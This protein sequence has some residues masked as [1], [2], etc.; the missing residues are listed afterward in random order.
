MKR[1]MIRKHFWSLIIFITLISSLGGLILL[2]KS[3]PEKVL[4]GNEFEDQ[5]RQHVE[6]VP[7]SYYVTNP[8]TSGNHNAEPLP[9]QIYNT[10]ISDERQVHNLEH[11]GVIIQYKDVNDI[12][13]AAKL[14]DLYNNT[15]GSFGKIILAPRSNMDSKI[16]LTSWTRL[17][18]L[19]EFDSN[20]ISTFIKNNYGK[21]P[22]PT[23]R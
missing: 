18:T 6:E 14:T 15:K 2:V 19:N 11:G 16:A 22:E 13:L 17:E 10:E 23:G 5:G 9:W 7:V 3:K 20:A 8:P 21:S 12:V 1:H 4:Q